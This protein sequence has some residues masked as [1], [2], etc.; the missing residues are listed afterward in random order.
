MIT[1]A[2]LIYSMS[3][4]VKVDGAMALLFTDIFIAWLVCNAAVKIWGG[5]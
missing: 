3:T 4:G 2:V 5:G 1:I